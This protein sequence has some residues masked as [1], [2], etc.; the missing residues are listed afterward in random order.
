MEKKKGRR[1]VGEYFNE[2][3][4]TIGRIGSNLIFST[5]GRR[6][7]SERVVERVG[8]R[9]DAGPRRG[10]CDFVVE[11]GVT[12]GGTMEKGVTLVLAR[13]IYFVLVRHARAREAA[14]V[15]HA[16]ARSGS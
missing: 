12:W 8:K 15:R 7:S 14:L 4:L 3:R 9:A 2:G 16:R 13:C 11:A 6:I 5:F 10:G 1:A